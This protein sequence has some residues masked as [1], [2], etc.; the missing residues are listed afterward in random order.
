MEN[1]DDSPCARHFHS[2]ALFKNNL[3][4]FG[5]KSNGYHNDLRKYDLESKLWTYII[6]DKNRDSIPSACYGQSLSV[7]GENMYLFGGYDN[8][9]FCCE[10]LYEFC[11]ANS[12]WTKIKFNK[13]YKNIER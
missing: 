13:D 7:F 3:Y 12:K 8:D 10:D 2:I 1:N 6:P 11:F 5:G 9:G 4:I